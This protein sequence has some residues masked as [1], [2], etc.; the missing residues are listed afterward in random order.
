MKSIFP[1][2][3]LIEMKKMYEMFWVI[4]SVFKENLSFK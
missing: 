4:M 3:F 2:V 1:R